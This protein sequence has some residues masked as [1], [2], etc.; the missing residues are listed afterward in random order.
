MRCNATFLREFRPR[1]KANRAADQ[2]FSF[3]AL[4]P[5]VCVHQEQLKTINRDFAL[6]VD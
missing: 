1:T 5:R 2:I 4:F 6:A 3:E